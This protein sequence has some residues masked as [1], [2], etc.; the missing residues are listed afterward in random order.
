[1]EMKTSAV[2]EKVSSSLRRFNNWNTPYL[3]ALAR[4]WDTLR[5]RAKLSILLAGMILVMT[6][7][8]YGFAVYQTT[9]E[10]KLSA[11]H[12]G[13]AVGEALKDEVAYVLL[14]GNFPALNYSFRRLT[15][16]RHDIAYV[17]LLDTKGHVL[18]HSDTDYVGRTMT[19]PQTLESL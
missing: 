5:I 13:E 16:S 18:S 3:K 11:I 15:S 10:I 4:F 1:M 12:K 14:A 7:F 6:G 2:A 17:S 8:F 9:R 19:D